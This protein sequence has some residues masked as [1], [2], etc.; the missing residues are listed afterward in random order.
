VFR[1]LTILLSFFIYVNT[2][3]AQRVFSLKQAVDTALKN[4][5][6]LKQSELQME[7]AGIDWRQAKTNLLPNLN[8]FANHGINQGRSIDPFT[9]GYIDQRVNYANYGLSSGITVFNGLNLQNSIRQTSLAYEASKM[10]VQQQ[11]DNLTLN[12]ILAY[13]QVLSNEDL[14]AQALSQV[15]VSRQQVARLEKM[16]KEGAIAPSLLSNLRGELAGNELAVVNSQNQLATSRLNL[17]QLMNVAYD[18][19]IKFERIPI[20]AFSTQYDASA[21]DIY[22]TA[23]ENLAMVKAANLRKLSAQK[24]VQV[25]KGQLYPNL[26][27]NGNVNTNYSSVA[28]QN[29]FLNNSDVETDSYV[30]IDNVKTP[31]ISTQPNFKTDKITYNKQLNNNLYTTISLDLRIPLFNNFSQRNRIKKA[32]LQLKNTDYV[33]ETTKIQL[34]QAIE[35]AY[36]NM[37]AAKNSYDA[38][39][40]QVEAF[41]LSFRIAEVRFNAGVETVIDYV[42]AK[43]NYDRANS[44]L[45]I[46]RYDYL[47]RTKILDYYRGKAL[48]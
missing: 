44:N 6:E 4:N 46:A 1:Y 8:G 29:I 37:T 14:L 48:W 22:Q 25:A 20:D 47:L 35:Q 42:I 36:A 13:L 3:H 34:R 43:N 7:S 33:A 19:A 28:T 39:S 16:N 40:K 30:M 26:S 2:A 23:L 17:F 38:L 21:N 24:G 15:D 27:L 5:L 31:V 10:D 18:S 45:I 32:A 41:A 9:N 11:K 12:V